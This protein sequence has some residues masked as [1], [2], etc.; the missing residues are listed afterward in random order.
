ML[1]DIM[2]VCDVCEEEIPRG[3]P[4]KKVSLPDEAIRMLLSANDPAVIPSMN[5]NPDGTIT[6]DICLTCTANMGSI[7]Q[8]GTEQ[9]N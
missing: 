4:Y 6:L 2:R 3:Q 1:K 8:S 7:A 9:V 5:Q